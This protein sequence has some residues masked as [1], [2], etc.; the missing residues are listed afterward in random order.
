M[1]DRLLPSTGTDKAVNVK[2]LLA[3]SLLRYLPF[4]ISRVL[5]SLILG[6]AISQIS[7]VLLSLIL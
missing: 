3:I 1:I 4:V 2:D 5:F 6:G 7:A